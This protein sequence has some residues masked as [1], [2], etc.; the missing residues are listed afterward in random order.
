MFIVSFEHVKIRGLI[1]RASSSQISS[2]KNRIKQEPSLSL[3]CRWL[4]E[5]Q[6]ESAKS[7]GWQQHA[8]NIASK[9]R[10]SSP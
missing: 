7:T 1:F 4:S 9:H 2:P 3:S 10:R 5:V 8:R 6:A